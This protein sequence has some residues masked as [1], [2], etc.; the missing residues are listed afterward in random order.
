MP[1]LIVT[2]CLGPCFV[3]RLPDE[4]LPFQEGDQS[5]SVLCAGNDGASLVL[6]VHC[7]LYRPNLVPFGHRFAV[8]PQYFLKLKSAEAI[9]LVRF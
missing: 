8:A 7:Y 2:D 6:H 4:D 9:A 5:C 3:D 1:Y